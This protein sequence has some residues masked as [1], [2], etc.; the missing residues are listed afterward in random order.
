MVRTKQFS[1]ITRASLLCITLV[2]FELQMNTTSAEERWHYTLGQ[3]KINQ[4]AQFCADRQAVLELARLFEEKG[5]RRGFAA[6]LQHDSCTTR[7]ESFT[8][9]DVIRQVSVAT[10]AGHSYV[11]TFVEV[12]ISNEMIE[13][14]VTTRE[15][16][17]RK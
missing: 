11:M 10:E 5:P 12:S 8:P 3:T 13:F 7:V 2:V 15:V 17:K 6:L 16:R 4:Q 14:L 1:A 9:L